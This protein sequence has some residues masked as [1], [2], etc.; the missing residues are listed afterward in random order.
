MPVLITCEHVLNDYDFENYEF[1]NVTYFSNE[2]IFSPIIYLKNK[3]IFRDTD[4]I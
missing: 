3:R 1:L 2:E 4:S